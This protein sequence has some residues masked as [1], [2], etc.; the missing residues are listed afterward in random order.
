VTLG[1]LVNRYMETGTVTKAH[2][3]ERIS[4]TAFLRHPICSR[5]L[6]ELPYR[7]LC[8]LQ[9]ERLK[10]ILAVSV[11]RQLDPV[12]HLIEIAR[13]EWGLPI[14]EN[15][16]GSDCGANPNRQDISSQSL[17]EPRYLS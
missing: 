3:N 15:P 9:D 4:L 2:E 5:R 10:V 8:G 13:R 11:K 17:P 12:H 14:K 16:Q 6:S 1:D 7:G